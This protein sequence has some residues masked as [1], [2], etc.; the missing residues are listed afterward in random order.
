MRTLYGKQKI[1]V[2]AALAILAATAKTS[3]YANG[4]DGNGTGAESMAMGGTDVAWVQ[5]PLEALGDNPAGLGFLTQSEMDLGGVGAFAE[6]RFSKPT[7]NSNGT[8]DS[9][10]AGMPEGALGIPLGKLPAAVGIGFIPESLL[11]AHWNYVDPPGAP[12]DFDAGVSYGNQLDKSEILVLRSAIGIGV[13]LSPRLSVGIS[14]GAVLNKNELV[15]PYIFQNLS[16]PDAGVDGAK[17]LLNLNTFGV[18]WNAQIGILYRPLDNLQFGLSYQ[19]KYRVVTTGDASGDAYAQFPPAPPGTYSFHYDAEV[20]N[21]FPDQVSLGGSWKFL[22]NWRVA[23]QVDWVDW[24]NAFTTLPVKLN[25]GTGPVV[26]GVLGTS[27]S[28]SIPLNWKSEFVYRV[29]LE[30]ALTDDLFLRAGYCYGHSPV[31]NSTLTPLTA[32]IMDN[33]VTAGVGYRWRS[34]E[35]DLAY[36]YDLPATQN[37]AASSLLSGEYANSSTKVSIHWFA[38]MMKF[39]F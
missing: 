35:F 20:D 15:T 37:V 14:I 26:P 39:T 24:G 2:Q 18:G 33:T 22:P 38:A 21:T 9:T 31:P 10:P 28:D 27:F 23:A 5:S 19:N 25:N 30:Y 16:A 12:G 34:C 8:L 13:A 29:G 7:A 36:Q 11:L 4:I 17:T 1:R 32:A 3:V 6:G